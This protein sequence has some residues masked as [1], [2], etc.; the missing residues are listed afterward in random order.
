MRRA[1]YPDADELER[2]KD[3][4]P[5][6]YSEIIATNRE[7]RIVRHEIRRN[8]SAARIR[9]TTLGQW[10]GFIIELIT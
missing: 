7:E 10:L 6:F 2:L 8:E 1:W 3:D 9:A 4:H 5:D